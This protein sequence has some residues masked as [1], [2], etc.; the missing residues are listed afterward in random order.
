MKAAFYARFSTDLQRN[1]SID[2]QF[3]NCRKR[4][5]LEGWDVVATFADHAISGADN[6]RPQYRAM[7]E[8]A[9]RGDFDILLVDD[10]SRFSR[11]QVESERA[12]RR[13]EF[14]GIR[15]LAVSDGYDSQ[16]KMAT[17]KI[18]RGVKSLINEMRLDELRE[19]VHR[20]LTGQALKRFWCGGKPYGYKLRPITDASHL[21]AYGQPAKIGTILVIDEEQAKIVRE[22]FDRYCAGESCHAIAVELNRRN[23]PSAGSSWKRKAR[24]TSGWMGSSVRV[25]LRNPLYKGE[26]RWN[27]SQFVRDPDSGKYLRRSRPK[28][29][30]IT[31]QI[32]E[33]RIVTIEQFQNVNSRTRAL[34]VSDPRLKAG[35]RVKYML[36]GLLRCEV[37]NAHYVIADKYSYACSSF[38][39][40]GACSNATRVNRK[41]LEDTILGPIRTDLKDPALVQRMAAEIERGYEKEIEATP[42]R[43]AGAPRE[44]KAVEERIE[45]IRS[46]TELTNDERHVLIETAEAKRRELQTTQSPARPQVMVSAILPKAAAMY[47]TQID[48]GL[49][50]DVRASAEGR[51]ILR[52]MLGPIVLSPEPDGS[53]WANYRFNPAALVR[54][55]GT[56]GRGDRI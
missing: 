54:A 33:L 11:D 44:L 4:A 15:L 39:N 51:I 50:G 10:L 31:H 18:Q 16:M 49:A 14:G 5:E 23:V 12:I 41:S 35:G 8:A 26:Q 13:L 24:R 42:L 20:G 27:S 7:L 36:S 47:V 52:E 3:R 55:A 56:Y 46:M 43:I 34:S 28:S 40:G 25:I 32:D 53:L 48:D 30:W 21:D 22:I 37:C 6:N 38:L 1:S 29:E 9:A 2:D 45:K 17:R 19:Q